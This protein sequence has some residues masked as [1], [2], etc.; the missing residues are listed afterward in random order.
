MLNPFGY[1]KTVGAAMARNLRLTRLRVTAVPT[2]L[3]T[4]NPT[5]LGTIVPEVGSTGSTSV[6]NT[7]FRRPDRAPERTVLENSLAVRSRL[8]IGNMA[9]SEFPPKRNHY[10]H[11]ARSLPKLSRSKRKA[12]Y[13]PWYGG[14]PGLH[15]LREYACAVGSR[16]F[17]HDGGY[18]AEKS[19]CSRWS[20]PRKS[21]GAPRLL[22]LGK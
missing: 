15:G 11:L 22:R 21:C 12:R 20:T 14:R 16:A 18:S 10:R 19:A 2:V 9:G 13:G 17:W 3:A 6:Y 8:A 5:L 1:F 7:K 4:M